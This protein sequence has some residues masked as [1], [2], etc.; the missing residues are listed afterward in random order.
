[1]LLVNTYTP[2]D[3]EPKTVLS[4][5]TRLKLIFILPLGASQRDV[6]RIGYNIISGSRLAF[7]KFP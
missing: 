1:M 2:P 5:R 6:Q 4:R 7:N 3:R